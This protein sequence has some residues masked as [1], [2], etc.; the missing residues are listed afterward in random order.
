MKYCSICPRECNADREN[1]RLGFCLCDDKIKVAKVMLHHWE[2]PVIS[3]KNGSGAIFFSGCPLKCV[4]CQNQ[5]ISQRTKGESVSENELSD[6]MLDLQ[7]KGAH[8]I[9]LVTPTHF[10]P[11]IIKSL[12]IAKPKLKI[13][14]VYNTSGYEKVE[15]LRMLD[16]YVDIY[17]PDF[18]YYSSELSSKYSKA[19]DY[20]E[21]ASKAL[22]EMYR[23]VGKVVLDENGI[24]Q[25]GMI[26]RHLVLPAC[27]KDSI[28]VLEELC[29]IV[30]VSDIK[31][32]LMSQYTPDFAP[33]AYPELSRRIT[34]FEYNS[35]LDKA[36]ELGFDGFFQEKD[37]ATKI[38]TPEF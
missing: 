2:E 4:F 14:V 15:T 35:V 36:L 5:D 22:L 16:G 29:K 28:R 37:S 30:P 19:P 7:E 31:L 26:V 20:F 17:L 24:M 25:K 23:Q 11:Q 9:N 21:V 32:S 34:T 13:P 33:V 3:G 10:V 18:K 1:G 12:D 8:N 6:I 38:Y 27:R